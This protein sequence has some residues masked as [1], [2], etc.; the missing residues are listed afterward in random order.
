M[1]IHRH[2]HNENVDSQFGPQAHAYLASPVHAQGEDLERMAGLVGRRPDAVALDLGCGGG[3]A[4]FRLAP[5]V[6]KVV[7]CDLSEAMLGV[8]A[9]EAGFGHRGDVRHVGRPG[10][11]GEH[12]AGHRFPRGRR[13]ARRAVR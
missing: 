12:A 4:A 1:S 9:G 5:L 13:P 6:G 11:P 10:E 2:S 3:H 7:A 8:V